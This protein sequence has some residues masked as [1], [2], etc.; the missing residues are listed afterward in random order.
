MIK[1]VFEVYKQSM[2]AIAKVIV[3]PDRNIFP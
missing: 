1:V 2:V 3:P